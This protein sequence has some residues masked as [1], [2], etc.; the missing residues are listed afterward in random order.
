MFGEVKMN[1]ELEQQF[2]RW[3]QRLSDAS[4]FLLVMNR[5]SQFDGLPGYAV[6]SETVQALVSETLE[7]MESLRDQTGD[8]ENHL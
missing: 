1:N 8:E 5:A 2:D 6:L 4:S 7:E 3:Q